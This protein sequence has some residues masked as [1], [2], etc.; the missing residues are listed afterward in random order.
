MKEEEKEKIEREKGKRKEK[1]GI[2]RMQIFGV[3]Y[4][5]FDDFTSLMPATSWEVV[6]LWFSSF[7]PLRK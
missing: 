3:S 6:P 4:N 1:K 5:T 2:L 7:S